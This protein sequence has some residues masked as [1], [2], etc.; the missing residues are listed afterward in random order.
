MIRLEVE[1]TEMDETMQVVISKVCGMSS[2]PT[3][4]EI[5]VASALAGLV[6]EVVD[7]RQVEE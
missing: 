1:L 5:D 3:R 4:R 2:V 6:N 7:G